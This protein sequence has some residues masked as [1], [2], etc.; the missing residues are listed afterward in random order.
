MEEGVLWAKTEHLEPAVV[1]ADCHC[2]IHVVG[3]N[4]NTLI[5][6]AWHLWMEEEAMRATPP[7]EQSKIFHLP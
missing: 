6:A 5:D 3:A 4:P 2:H 7:V 1:R